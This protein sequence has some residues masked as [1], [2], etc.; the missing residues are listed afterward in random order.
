[1]VIT[2]IPF[3]YGDSATLINQ[4]N[5]IAIYSIIMNKTANNTGINTF[6]LVNSTTNATLSDVYQNCTITN[7]VSCKAEFI[8]NP[9]S[10]D[11][12]EVFDNGKYIES[13]S[14][15]QNSVITYMPKFSQQEELIYV[16]FNPY[17]IYYIIG[18]IAVILIAGNIAYY[19][20]KKSRGEI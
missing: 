3:I 10:W 19:K 9:G 15:Q 13:I 16:K 17:T 5:Q 14:L 18:G 7:I 20:Y 12:I 8:I 2:L 4:N 1:M 11:A 6:Q